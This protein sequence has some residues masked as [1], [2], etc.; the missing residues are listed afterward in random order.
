MKTKPCLLLWCIFS[1]IKNGKYRGLRVKYVFFE[2][3][4]DNS[5]NLKIQLYFFKE[6]GFINNDDEYLEVWPGK[7]YLTFRLL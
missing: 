6:H 4:F 3:I 1:K 2:T 7:Y 5:A